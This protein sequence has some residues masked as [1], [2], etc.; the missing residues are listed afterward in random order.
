MQIEFSID[1]IDQAYGKYLWDYILSFVYLSTLVDL[2]KKRWILHLPPT[3]FLKSIWEQSDPRP[4]SFLIIP[5]KY[6]LNSILR[7]NLLII[8][9][10]QAEK[11]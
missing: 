9:Y 6:F 5:K 3:M 8:A 10:L 2:S 1:L 4:N 11:E 7:V